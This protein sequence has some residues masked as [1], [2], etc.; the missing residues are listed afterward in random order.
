[1]SKAYAYI[2]NLL[3]NTKV[4]WITKQKKHEHIKEEK[5]LRNKEEKKNYVIVKVIM[6]MDI[7][8]L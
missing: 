7:T 6:Q 4:I 5:K 8:L 3:I 1:M 2:G